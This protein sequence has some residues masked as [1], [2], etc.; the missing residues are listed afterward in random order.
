[1]RLKQIAARPIAMAAAVVL[2]ALAVLGHAAA[3]GWCVDL[4]SDGWRLNGCIED[5]DTVSWIALGDDGS[6]WIWTNGD[7]Q[8][9]STEAAD[10]LAYLT[11]IEPTPETWNAPHPFYNRDD[12]ES[13]PLDRYRE[14][15]YDWAFYAPT[16]EALYDG[17]RQRDHLVALAEAHQSGGAY[18]PDVIK[19]SFALDA[20]NIFWLPAAV[21]A[22]KW[23]HDP[24]GWRPAHPGVHQPY[25][26][27]WIDIKRKWALGFDEAEI[28]A[29][30]RMLRSPP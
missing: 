18:W 2:A 23:S 28:A 11:T 12:W 3:D 8:R 14:A 1:M 16:L 22:E 25:A 24:A 19:A 26:V 17:P 6:F 4:E 15:E 9:Q 29:L 10:A 13:F 30:R 27:R 7:W 21:N 20:Q 5:G